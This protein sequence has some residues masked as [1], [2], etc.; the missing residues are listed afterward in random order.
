MAIP[1]AVVS[2]CHRP[3]TMP[4]ATGPRV[5]CERRRGQAP[6]EPTPRSDGWRDVGADLPRAVSEARPTACLV[7]C[8]SET[9]MTPL[10]N[11]QCSLRTRSV[12]ASTLATMSAS[13]AVGPRSLVARA[14]RPTSEA[15]STRDSP[16]WILM[17]EKGN[18]TV[19]GVDGLTT[20]GRPTISA[21]ARTPLAFARGVCPLSADRRA[22]VAAS[23]GA[24][25]LVCPVTRS[26]KAAAPYRGPPTSAQEPDGRCS[27][28]YHR[29]FTLG[30]VGPMRQGRKSLAAG[31]AGV[32]E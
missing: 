1:P 26:G 23:R 18:A 4:E 8:T 22:E 2:R 30:T 13:S 6:V 14:N 29:S 15:S 16:C 9:A 11:D 20:A 21:G 12:R 31:V 24:D 19:T 3:T 17:V 25:L 27:W 5:T 32:D 7:L 28:R 10:A